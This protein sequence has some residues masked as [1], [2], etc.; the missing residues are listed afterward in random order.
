MHTQIGKSIVLAGLIRARRSMKCW[1]I[2][3]LGSSIMGGQSRTMARII[4]QSGRPYTRLRWYGG[5][6][7]LTALMVA[8]CGPG[9]SREELGHIITN[10]A[11][12]PGADIL[13]AQE[14]P[15]DNPAGGEKATAPPEP[16]ATPEPAK[17]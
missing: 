7:V 11:D 3:P 4:H 8:G 2:R 1:K 5:A 13:D 14:Q 10:A 16:S 6:F 9:A 12:L 17:Y 15:S